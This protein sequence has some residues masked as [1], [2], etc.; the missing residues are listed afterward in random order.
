ML[1]FQNFQ[2][3]SV[4]LP[5]GVELGVLERVDDVGGPN[6]SDKPPLT[7]AKVLVDGPGYHES[8]RCSQLLDLLDLSQCDCT[9]DELCDLKKL[10]S[11]QT[12]IFQMS[13]SEL[14]RCDMVQHRIDTGNSLPIKQQPYRTPVIKRDKIAELIKNMQQ[15]GIVQPS[16]SPWASPVVLVPKKDGSI[17]TFLY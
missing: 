14:G 13:D 17:D 9:T 1:P 11:T 5:P 4:D 8:D 15:Q 10:L 16:S 6:S 7:C 12:D 2:K 3:H